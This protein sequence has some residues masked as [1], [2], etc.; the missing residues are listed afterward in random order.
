MIRKKRSF[1]IAKKLMM[2]RNSATDPYHIWESLGFTALPSCLFLIVALSRAM[3]VSINHLSLQISSAWNPLL[4]PT[5]FHRGLSVGGFVRRAERSGEGAGRTGWV[6]SR[7]FQYNIYRNNFVICYH[8][9]RNSI[10]L[11]YKTKQ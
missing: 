11:L 8:F 7:I 10:F 3:A 6:G 4:K 2:V 5:G 1:R 9:N